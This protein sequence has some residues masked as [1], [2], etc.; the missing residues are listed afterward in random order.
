MPLHTVTHPYVPG[1]PAPAVAFNKVQSALG[2]M[3]T[4]TVG[5]LCSTVTYVGYS[6]I[7]GS[8]PGL[9]AFVLLAHLGSVGSTLSTA[10]VTPYF[11]QLSSK[12]QMGRVMSLQSMSSSAGRVVGPPL[13]GALY[14]L[15]IHYP[16][17]LSAVFTA[18]AAAVFFFVYLTSISRPKD[19]LASLD[20]AGAKLIDPTSVR[21]SK[22]EEAVVRDLQAR[23]RTTLITRGYDL[24]CAATVEALRQILVDAFPVTEREKGH[25]D[26]DVLKG[27]ASYLHSRMVSTRWQMA[28]HRASAASEGI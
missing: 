14:A 19:S 11:S 22:E 28:Y 16:Y 27:E 10:S 23:L 9:I 24:K 7:N 3:R 4:A 5:A 26:C 13:F 18:L 1:V 12:A 15:N 6:F 17:R 20:S 21:L 8:R 25:A 2:L